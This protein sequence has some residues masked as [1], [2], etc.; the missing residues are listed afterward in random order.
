MKAV[1]TNADLIAA[2]DQSLFADLRR[3][4]KP[5]TWGQCIIV[6]DIML[7]RTL[8]LSRLTM[9]GLILGGQVVKMS[10]PGAPTSGSITSS[11]AEFAPLDEAVITSEV[12][13]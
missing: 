12:L 5:F 4:A 10:T 6:P 7:N 1:V 9:L 3:K 8:L 2:G 13:P 11:P